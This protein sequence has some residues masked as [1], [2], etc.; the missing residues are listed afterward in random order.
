MQDGEPQ[1][2][3]LVADDSAVSRKLVE[4]TLSEKRYSLIFAKSGRETIDLF[5]EHHPALV[6]V[7]WIMPDLT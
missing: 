4:Q 3:V 2:R 1:I 6:I 5:A 7:D